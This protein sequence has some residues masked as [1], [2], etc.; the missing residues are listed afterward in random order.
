LAEFLATI[1]LFKTKRML[2]LALL[3]LYTG[4]NQPYQLSTFGNRFFDAQTV[5]LGMV[6]FYGAEIFG[7]LWIGKYLDQACESKENQRFA[8][9]RCLLIFFLVTS[10]SFVLCYYLESKST[11]TDKGPLINY[12]SVD[13]ILPMITYALWG[14]SDSQIQT[15]SYWLM[16][17]L[18]N[19]GDDQARAV[20]FYKMI[21]SLG[22][23]VGFKF[24]PVERMSAM[25]QLSGTVICFLFGLVFS[26]KE[27]P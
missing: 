15:Y 11:S 1:A 9:R 12:T 7:G 26:L 23:M 4:Y 5:G 25:L 27:L 8:A 10:V 22:W 21:Q 17:V 20:G 6:V 19:D 14:F 3:F 18:Y 16:G 2:L 24:A 13:V